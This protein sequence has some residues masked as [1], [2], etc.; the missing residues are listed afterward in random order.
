SAE[1]R[2]NSNIALPDPL[3]GNSQW[4]TAYSYD[5]NNNLTSRT[6]ARN[7]TTNIT[8]D[9]LKREVSRSYVNDPTNTPAVTHV[10]EVSSTPGA[11]E[12]GT[13]RIVAVQS[14]SGIA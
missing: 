11:V 2:S 10:W 7:I 5:G 3:T 12:N 4:S 9:A 6:D 14:A 8:Y 13:G 1:A